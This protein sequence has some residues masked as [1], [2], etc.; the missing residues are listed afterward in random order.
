MSLALDHT[1]PETIGS[2]TV[3]P[4]A[5]LFPLLE[6]KDYEE[7]K[8]SIEQ[9][10][11]QQP[12]IVRNGVLIDGRNRLKV[13]LD[14]RRQPVVQE[15]NGKLP[16]EEYI[17]IE[18]LFRRHLTDDQRMMITTQVMLQKETEAAQARQQEAG[19]QQGRS[20]PKKLGAKSTQAIRQPKVSEKIAAAAKG[21][22][23]QARQAIAVAQTAPELVEPVKAGTMPL[24]EAAR[25]ATDRRA[26][27]HPVPRQEPDYRGAEVRIT[28]KIHDAMKK[29]PMRR[30][31]L[32]KAILEALKHWEDR[33]PGNAA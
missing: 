2:Y 24:K 13:L 7:L 8:K 33:R 5:S 17:L 29:F 19:K 9:H 14:L 1:A 23:Y 4:I 28:G 27:K 11:Q 25:V 31:D 21:T 12:I 30:R 26:A 32:Q 3:H 20:R 22:D 10:G 16:V 18:N 15:Y 6:G